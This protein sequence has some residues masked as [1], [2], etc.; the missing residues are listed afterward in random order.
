MEMFT[1]MSCFRCIF[2]ALAGLA[3]AA[4]AFADE[5]PLPRPPAAPPAA[6]PS[7]HETPAA[8]ETA[9]PAIELRAHLALGEADRLGASIEPVLAYRWRRFELGVGVQL[10]GLW[11][12]DDMPL[13]SINYP[14]RSYRDL[15]ILPRAMLGVR[16]R[17]GFWR[18][19]LTAGYGP[20]WMHAEGG[21]PP[22][23]EV[24]RAV[25]SYG[26]GF[27]FGVGVFHAE[28]QWFGYLR[29]AEEGY[30]I[31]AG[32]GS[33]DALGEAGGVTSLGVAVPIEL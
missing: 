31:A 13:G 26:A 15:T 7:P 12:N 4:S 3:P 21:S 27:G 28:V 6:E 22:L 11:A 17:D 19:H 2:C 16:S 1:P 5:A 14:E 33:A 25:W 20:T 18:V 32:E 29:H 23:P 10:L 8:A 9:T 30:T 24:E